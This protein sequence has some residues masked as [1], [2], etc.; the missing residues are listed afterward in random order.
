MTEAA[1]AEVGGELL[2]DVTLFDVYQG[3]GVEDGFRSLALGL[4]WQHL[5]RTL[6]DTEV[7]EQMERVIQALKQSFDIKIRD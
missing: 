5:S 4:I 7:N 2:R 3:K 1:L 6:V